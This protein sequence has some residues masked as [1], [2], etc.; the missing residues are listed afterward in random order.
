MVKL[1]ILLFAIQVVWAEKVDFYHE[2]SVE[3]FKPPSRL[4][5]ES[6]FGFSAAYDRVSKRLIISAPREN[7][8]GEVYQCNITTHACSKLDRTIRRALK[9]YTH[10]YWFGATVRAGSSFVMAC[11]PRYL[12]YNGAEAIM[13]G[14]CYECKDGANYFE[15]GAITPPIPAY[16]P[17]KPLEHDID[18]LGWSMDIGD[19]DSLIVGGPAMF[20]KT[21]VA[22]V[23]VST[24]PWS[25]KRIE[26]NVSAQYN[27][28]DGVAVGYFMDP[29][30]ISYAV[31]STYGHSGYGQ[32]YFY[33]Y[34]TDS[35]YITTLNK[36]VDLNIVGSM[37]GAVLCA[38]NL[39]N[40]VNSN[41][42]DL[43]VGAPRYG[44]KS[45][46]SH[47][48]GAVYVYVH[49]ATNTM[50]YRNTITTGKYGS[51]FGSAILNIGDL[52]GD[53]KDDIAIGAPFEDDGRGTVYLYCGSTLA[54][55]KTFTWLQRIVPASDHRSF[56]LSLATLQDFDE[57]GCNE[58][59]VGSPYSDKM[60]LYR[61]WAAITITNVYARFPNLQKRGNNK[62]TNFV[63]DVCMDVEYPP[64]PKHIIAD[65]GILVQMDHPDA[66]LTKPNKNG[67]FYF[68]ISL[69]DKKLQYCKPID[70]TLPQLGNYEES[71][72]YTIS[73]KLLNNPIV[74]KKFNSERVI[75]T[76][77]SKLLRMDS[78]WAAE[79]SG[80]K[81]CK[82][83]L[84]L[85][86]DSG[87][88]FPYIIGS[89]DSETFSITVNNTG[90][91][92]YDPCIHMTVSGANLDRSPKDCSLENNG[93]WRCTPRKPLRA[94]EPWSITD[95]MVD[96]TPLTNQDRNIILHVTLYDNCKNK[97]GNITKVYTVPLKSYAK[98]IHIKGTT[99]IGEIVNMTKNDLSDYGK[100]FEHSYEISNTGP[101]NF[102]GLVAVVKMER[103]SYINIQSI[104]IGSS[105]SV[106]NECT[107]RG[108]EINVTAYCILNSL[109]KQHVVEIRIPM[110]IIPGAM[111][112]DALKT[113]NETVASTIAFEIGS[114][115]KGARIS[116]IVRLEEAIVPIWIFVVA[117]F[118]GIFI[119][120]ILIFIL[121]ECGFLQRKNKKHLQDLKRNVYRQS[122]RR[123]AIQPKR[124][125]D[126]QQ[127]MDPLMAELNKSI[128]EA[129]YKE[130]RPRKEDDIILQ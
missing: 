28:G 82:P 69:R 5:N 73:A 100:H 59:A 121:Y 96:M 61:C 71:I 4:P 33:T 31:S 2:L 24:K 21:G 75:L 120:I 60:A 65:I 17:L 72:T 128:M 56:G 99:D 107:V 30:N 109:S 50:E 85:K 130:I 20:K 53:G 34:D 67:L 74:N 12:F 87:L 44:S 119:L 86:I 48:D 80:N 54:T 58:L 8:I 63:F 40:M 22:A 23:S 106:E 43:L 78:V 46:F 47:D 18:T 83:K 88:S 94:D 3:N 81:E 97:H 38:A 55:S 36:E 35:H 92:A 70:F 39:N 102:V 14:Y 76:E 98:G 62:Q 116:T 84:E 15:K 111:S 113:K 79:C 110:D 6:Y 1:F 95:V 64:K 117:A 127:M 52:N 89:S 90:D 41:P 93:F 37:Y 123:S 77:N 42:T 115:K 112:Y 101:T 13:R 26:K 125:S 25:L 16:D 91:V 49:V 129:V 114:E 103:K 9:T 27:F 51:L 19:H 66:K 124:D 29:N 104:Y 126:R 105:K 122:V 7:N 10:D 45:S 11:A 68:K 32:V 108:D 57:N 118:F